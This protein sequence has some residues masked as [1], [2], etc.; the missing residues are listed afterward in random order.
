MATTYNMTTNA[1]LQYSQ[2]QQQQ[3]IPSSSLSQAPLH[4]LNQILE[5]NDSSLQLHLDPTAKQSRSSSMS[6][7]VSSSSA[8]CFNTFLMDEQQRAMSSSGETIMKSPNL[9]DEGTKLVSSMSNIS[10]LSLNTRGASEQQM[11]STPFEASPVI[12]PTNSLAHLSLNGNDQILLS[13]NRLSNFHSRKSSFSNGTNLTCAQQSTTPHQHFQKQRHPSYTNYFSPSSASHSRRTSFHQSG[14][15]NT[16]NMSTQQPIPI[17]MNPETPQINP[18]SLNNSPSGFYLNQTLP[19]SLQRTPTLSR[20]NSSNNSSNIMSNGL[21]N[22]AA[23]YQGMT[24]RSPKLDPI[25]SEV[26]MTPLTLNAPLN[27]ELM[28]KKEPE[29]PSKNKNNDSD[30]PF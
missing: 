1:K 2:Q 19:S 23:S 15:S 27:I 22:N 12:Q 28:N 18:S 5:E 9:V 8:S 3:I 13:S 7:T 21:Y 11:M 24:I 16:I 17:N 20:V 25:Y 6:S 10:L 26:P 14:Q 30:E 4:L 29:T